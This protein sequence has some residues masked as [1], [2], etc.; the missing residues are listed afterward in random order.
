MAHAGILSKDITLSY[1]SGT[2]STAT[3]VEIENLQEIPSLGGDVDTVEVTTLA[4]AAHTFIRGLK[5]YGDKLAFKFLYDNSAATSNYRVCKSLEAEYDADP[6]FKHEWKVTFP[7]GTEFAFE[8]QAQASIDAA[9]T[10][11][12][13]T[14][15]LNIA[16]SSDITVTD[17]V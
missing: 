11:A 17:P 8:G 15:T 6:E 9:G 16:I 7:D 10:N 12:A 4:D 14:F 2:G 5:N 13:L 1:K 3:Y